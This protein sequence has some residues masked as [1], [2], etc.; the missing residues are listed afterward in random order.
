MH[1][2]F[3]GTSVLG[4]L[5]QEVFSFHVFQL[6]S[7]FTWYVLNFCTIKTPHNMLA[8]CRDP[9]QETHGTR[10]R[11]LLGSICLDNY[12]SNTF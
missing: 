11:T 5:A 4:L 2:V 12:P 9:L 6:E 1:A 7:M 3:H 8:S 10:A